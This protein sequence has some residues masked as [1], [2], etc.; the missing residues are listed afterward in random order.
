MEKKISK[1]VLDCKIRILYVSKK[2]V[3]NA[4]KC[5]TG[6]FGTFAQFN[7][8]YGS[9]FAPVGDVSTAGAKYF[10]VA[11]RTAKKQNLFMKA[12]KGRSM[13]RGKAIYSMNTEELASIFHFPNVSVKAPMI[14]KVESKKVEP[15]MDLPTFD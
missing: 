12:Y 8:F 2:T 13:W 14:T 10:R 4:A 1:P 6:A 7:N 5:V 3:F 15:P 11:Q 9:S